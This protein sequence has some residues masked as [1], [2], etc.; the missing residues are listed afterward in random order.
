MNIET[1]QKFDLLSNEIINQLI[2]EYESIGT[3]KT[4]TMKKGSIESII[5][6]FVPILENLLNLELKSPTGNFYKHT[7]PYLP[8][9]DFKSW[10][11]N[12]LNLVIPLKY[13]GEQASL[14]I[15]DQTWKQDSV[16][17]CM[18]HPVKYFDT[19][20][21]VKGCPYEYPVDNLTDQEIDSDLYIK[22]LNHYPKYC[23]KGLSGTA[24]PFEVGSIIMFDNKKI[25][26]TSNFK[27]EKLGLSL[28][29][30]I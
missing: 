14:I 15:F 19:N 2:S 12:T 11:K 5:N 1:V 8:H 24:Y 7:I 27:G 25:H 18:N 13:T 17:W 9:T 10:V 16:T 29:F 30:S 6:W 23:L 26:C 21:G 3:Y 4:I 20:I 22:Y 28:R